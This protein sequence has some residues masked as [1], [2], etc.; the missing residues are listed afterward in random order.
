M[1]KKHA[2]I[3]ILNIDTVISAFDFICPADFS[4]CGE[5]HDFWEM[6]YVVDGTVGISGDER[7]YTLSRGQ[8]LFHKPMEFHRIWSAESA[9]PRFIIISFDGG[10]EVLERLHNKVFD[11]EPQYENL[12]FDV[13]NGTRDFI[14]N[15]SPAEEG[16]IVGNKLELFILS[17]SRQSSPEKDLYASR[18]AENYRLIVT[19]LNKHLYDNLTLG[20]IAAL[21]GMSESNLKKTF[22]KFSGEGVINYH[23]RLKIMKASEL[24]K[25]GHTVLEVSDMMSF[26][27]QGYFTK[28][29][30]RFMGV[31]PNDYKKNPPKAFSRPVQSIFAPDDPSACP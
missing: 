17:I 4:F 10:G 25:R 31:T 30:K 22:Q 12:V 21:C 11:I 5:M 20:N 23:N 19:V 2:L 28:V 1:Y 15:E 24:L 16:Q 18:S 6:V 27:S 14:R 3:R 9:P 26:S 7:L 29:F 13:L 8:A